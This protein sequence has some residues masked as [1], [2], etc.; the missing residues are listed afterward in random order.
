MSHP[1]RFP[2]T[3]SER[4]CMSARHKL[5]RI[6]VQGILALSGIVGAVAQS[7]AVFWFLFLVLLVA[8]WHSGE[9]RPDRPRR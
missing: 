4:H 9:I 1:I 2:V 6:T 3:T 8:A 7:W 5:N